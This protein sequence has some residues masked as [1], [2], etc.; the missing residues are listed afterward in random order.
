MAAI[1]GEDH[2]SSDG[3]LAGMEVLVKATGCEVSVS[4]SYR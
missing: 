1:A 3:S 2:E 4:M